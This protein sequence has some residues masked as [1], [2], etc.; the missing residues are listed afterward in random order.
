MLLQLVSGS[1]GKWLTVF[2]SVTLVSL[3][4]IYFVFVA[5]NNFFRDYSWH[6]ARTM[7]VSAIEVNLGIVCASLPAVKNGLGTWFPKLFGSFSQVQSV[8][9]II[10]SNMGGRAPHVSLHLERSKAE[11]VD[12]EGDSDSDHTAA[13]HETLSDIHMESISHQG[14]L[15]SENSDGAQPPSRSDLWTRKKEGDST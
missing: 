2:C 7:A 13:Y 6:G 9:E 5:E 11:T 14:T 1:L 10:S 3:A 12:L 8:G 4:R 15:K